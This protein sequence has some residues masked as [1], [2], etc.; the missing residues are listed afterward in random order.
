MRQLI[1]VPVYN[2]AATLAAVAEELRAHLGGSLERVL[3]VDDASTDGSRQQLE[4]LKT[5]ESRFGTLLRDS[6]A[7]YGAAMID[8]LRIGKELGFDYVITMDCDRQHQ[9]ADLATFASFD[10]L[11]DVV[12]GSRYLP[13]SGASGI[14][15]PAD[16]VEI[17]RRITNA[18][19]HRYGWNL[20][21]SFCGFKRYRLDRLEPELLQENGYAFPLEFWTYA[22]SRKLTIAEIPVHR[23]YVTDDRSFGE[24]L[25]RRFRRYKYYLRTWQ[26]A[27]RRFDADGA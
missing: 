1:V 19:N 15:P 16:R 24:D 6:N 26:K 13:L 14:A 4:E 27:R 23:I 9:P 25:D 18:L 20:T 11:V 5:R 8:G 12:S 3:F 2:E 10:P 22:H 21:D 17:N 7:G